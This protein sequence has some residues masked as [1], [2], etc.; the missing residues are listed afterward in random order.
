VAMQVVRQHVGL[1]VRLP[2]L[3][4]ARH[5]DTQ[6]ATQVTRLSLQTSFSIGHAPPLNKT[7]SICKPIVQLGGAVA[8]G[9]R[10]RQ[11][12]AHP[13]AQGVACAC[14]PVSACACMTSGTVLCRG[15]WPA[16]PA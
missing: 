11:R 9:D 1:P 10:C 2:G 13:H 7:N 15:Q 6:S 16:H 3:H 5:R 14:R 12:V 8:G 4:A